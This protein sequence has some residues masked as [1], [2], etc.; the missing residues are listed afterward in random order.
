MVNSVMVLVLVLLSFAKQTAAHL[1][2]ER[3][4]PPATRIARVAM[5]LSRDGAMVSIDA[6]CRDLHRSTSISPTTFMPRVLDDRRWSF[7]QQS[8]VGQMRPRSRELNALRSCVGRPL[9]RDERTRRHSPTLDLLARVPR[10]HSVRLKILVVQSGPLRSGG[11][12]PHL[13]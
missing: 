6:P 11:D 13:V 1:A 8:A 10:R 5:H 2:T 9:P 4:S 12:A 7:I 3:L